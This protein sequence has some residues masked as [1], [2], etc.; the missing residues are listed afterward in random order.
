LAGQIELRTFEHHPA[1]LH[2]KALSSVEVLGRHDGPRM[3]GRV[4]DVLPKVY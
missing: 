3:Q 2:A 4:P 1:E